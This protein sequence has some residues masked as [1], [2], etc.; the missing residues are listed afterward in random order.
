MVVSL[1][2][3]ACSS[4]LVPKRA[5][6]SIPFRDDITHVRLFM[7][8]RGLRFYAADRF[9]VINFCYPSVRVFRPRPNA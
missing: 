7:A 1:C 2:S 8:F 6:A 9:E 5:F 4:R 3:N